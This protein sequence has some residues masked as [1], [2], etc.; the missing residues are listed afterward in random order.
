[1]GKIF[2]DLYR[3]IE[4]VVM[5]NIL[6]LLLGMEL[7]VILIFLLVLRKVVVDGLDLKVWLLGRMMLFWV[8]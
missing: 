3:G 7:M 1:M 4:E 5:V 8:L 2:V 6:L